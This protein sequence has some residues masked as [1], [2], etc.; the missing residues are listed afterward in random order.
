MIVKPDPFAI[1]KSCMTVPEMIECLGEVQAAAAAD[2][3][4]AEVAH[5]LAQAVDRLHAL[6]RLAFEVASEAGGDA[7]RE[8]APREVSPRGAAVVPVG[9]PRGRVH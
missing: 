6:R 9:R 4:L 2:P 3:V 1:A 7:R 5:L 8:V